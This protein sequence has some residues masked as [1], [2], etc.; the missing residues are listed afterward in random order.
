MSGANRITNRN[1]GDSNIIRIPRDY[2]NDKEVPRPVAPF[3]GKK[4]PSF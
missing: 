4:H 3:G 1:H 2:K